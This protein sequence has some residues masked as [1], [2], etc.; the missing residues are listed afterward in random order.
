[1]T[2]KGK[3]IVIE[4]TDGSGKGTH[5]AL[6]VEWLRAEG[7]EVMPVDFPRHGQPSAY[8]VDRYLS[9]A[10]GPLSDTGPY[11]GSLF[12]ALDRF[13]ASF[14]I[15][16]ALKKGSIIVADRYVG[17]NM[18]H[19][20]GKIDSPDERKAYFKWNANLE[21]NILGIPHPD[22]N[23]VLKMPAALAQKFVDQKAERAYTKGRKRDIHEADL[24]HLRRAEQTYDE[25]C[26]Q[27]PDIF[28]KVDCY[29]GRE[30]RSVDDIQAEIRAL[31][32]QQII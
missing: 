25:L 29:D 13:E 32:R 21:Y 18:G 3:F 20:G 22:I 14:E 15:K 6:L 16:A 26:A 4:G 19:Q 11:R 23:I 1:M 30:V 12:Y 9:G 17:S 5:T 28:T 27:F 10:Y 7:R 2:A 8:F 31:V 24:D